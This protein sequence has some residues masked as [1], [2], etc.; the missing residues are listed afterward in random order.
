MLRVLWLCL[1]TSSNK[2]YCAVLN[3]V[4]KIFVLFERSVSHFLLIS[5]TIYSF[6]IVFFHI[7]LF[8]IA[9]FFCFLHAPVNFN[10]FD[11]F[12]K[13]LFAFYWFLIF[14]TVIRRVF[15]LQTA[16]YRFL[17][18]Y[19]LGCVVLF[20]VL[21]LILILHFNFHNP[22]PEHCMYITPHGPY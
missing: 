18:E 12:L 22:S 16:I 10:S 3:I 1:F 17:S 20:R 14:S 13:F 6:F 21:L 4:Q 15:Q 19:F 8:S 5:T 11:C 7:L 2:Q 9:F